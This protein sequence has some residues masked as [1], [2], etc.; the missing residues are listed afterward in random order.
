MKLL[1]SILLFSIYCSAVGQQLGNSVARTIKLDSNSVFLSLESEGYY[2][3]SIFNNGTINKFIYGG[4]IGDSEKKQS[5]EKAKRLNHLGGEF[6]TTLQYANANSHLIKDWGFYTSLSYNYNLGT[7]FTQDLYQLLFFGNKE[8]M[9]D[10]SV[11]SPSAYYLRDMNSFSFG[12]NKKNQLKIG[13]TLSSF[14]NNSG[15]EI[16]KGLFFTDSTGGEL[17]IDIE[18]NYFAVDTNKNIHL[19]SNN[20]IG[21][22]VDLE[23]VFQLK[24]GLNTPKIIVGVKN[25]GFLIQQNTYQISSKETY[26]YDGIAVNNLSN[27]ST[28]LLAPDAIEDSLGVQTEISNTTSILPFEIYFYQLPTYQKRIELIYGFRYKIQSAYKAFLYA[29]GNFKIN[30]NINTSTYI[31]HGGYGNFQWGIATQFALNNTRI[32]VTSNN[33]LGFFSNSAYGKSLGLSIAYQL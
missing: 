6:N 7:Q 2:S 10:T 17:S 33:V 20:A 28:D 4:F 24:E 23:T 19:F 14:N 12:L 31:S 18:G 15:A 3:S 32:G 13:L 9:G 5:L 22:G 8:L 25:V 30:N 1:Y 27:I 16:T 26:T 29:G 11:L 21:I